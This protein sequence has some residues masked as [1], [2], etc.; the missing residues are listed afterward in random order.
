MFQNKLLDL[1]E[2]QIDDLS[3]IELQS[4]LPAYKK[5]IVFNYIITLI[6]CTGVVIG[7]FNL[8]ETLDYRNLSLTVL[9]I[10]ALILIMLAI[11]MRAFRYRKYGIREHDVIYEYGWLVHHQV[12]IP[13][14][15]LQYV[16]IHQ[17][18]LMRKLGMAAIVLYTAGNGKEALKISGIALET[19]NQIKTII[20]NKIIVDQTV[21]SEEPKT[22]IINEDHY[23][24]DEP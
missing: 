6:I 9:A 20:S 7:L 21:H 8:D 13:F 17:G 14:N 3:T 11:S 4:I 12:V 18:F 15:R 10:A 16:K 22:Q 23:T 24:T 1:N 5:V 2:Y 19:A